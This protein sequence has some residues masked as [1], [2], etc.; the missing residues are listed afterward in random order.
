MKQLAAIQ[1]LP[2]QRA[3]VV[4][5]HATADV[6]QSRIVGRVEHVVSGQVGHFQTL[7]ELLACMAGV[8]GPPTT[9]PAAVPET[10][11]HDHDHTPR[12]DRHYSLHS[13]PRKL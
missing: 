1:P 10:T 2:M 13:A 6:A 4:Q 3:F 11:T 8:L 9:T 5:L 7:E 12:F